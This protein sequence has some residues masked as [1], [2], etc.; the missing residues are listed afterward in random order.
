MTRTY[1]AALTAMAAVGFVAVIS[2]TGCSSSGVG[3]PC[4]PEEEYVSDFLGFSPAEVNVESKSFQC[5]TRLCLVNHFQGRVSCP[6][7]QKEDASE[8][9]GATTNPAFECNGGGASN[10]ANAQCCVPGVNQPVLSDTDAA[11]AKC[12]T[13]SG[14]S[15]SVC[16]G[17]ELQTAGSGVVKNSQVLPNCTDR[18]A[19]NA[20]YCSCRCANIDGQ[21]NDG[22]NYCQC[23]SGFSCTQLVSP[24]GSAN[25]LLT[26]A[27]CIKQNTEYTGTS[28]ESNCVPGSPNG[29]SQNCG[30]TNTANF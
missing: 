19:D 30:P 29:S 15:A 8:A 10:S 5:L 1:Q 23:P 13:P 26:G 4:I 17:A 16:T 7:G 14:G 22:A 18:Q 6:Y 2:G 3:D 24:I 9:Y 27:Y 28:C 11:N 21:T 12:P 25:A 20:V